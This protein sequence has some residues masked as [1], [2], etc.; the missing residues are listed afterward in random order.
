ME[1][2]EDIKK[3]LNECEYKISRGVRSLKDKVLISN[4]GID[5]KTKGK[6]LLP[7]FV[8]Q[9]W[10]TGGATGGNCWG[11][12]AKIINEIEKEVSFESLDVFLDKLNPKLKQS[13]YDRVLNQVKYGEILDKEYYGNYTEKTFKYIKHED[14]IACLENKYEAKSCSE[15]SNSSKRKIKV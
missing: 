13:I 11:D 2:I 3:V 15:T 12:V 14:I 9:S 10:L 8:S 6:L 1:N 5:E 7:V 4:L